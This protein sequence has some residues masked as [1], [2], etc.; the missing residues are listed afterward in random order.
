MH[1]LPKALRPN[2][3]ISRDPKGRDNWFTHT[4]GLSWLGGRRHRG[5]FARDVS[6]KTAGPLGISFCSMVA[7]TKEPVQAEFPIPTDAR[8]IKFCG[9]HF[10]WEDTHNR[11]DQVDELYLS[12]DLKSYGV[13]RTKPVKSEVVEEDH[14]D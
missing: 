1:L 13:V 14:L 6:F 11:V 3:V 12:A 8:P 4:R 10:R 9:T 2:T 7:V 5:L